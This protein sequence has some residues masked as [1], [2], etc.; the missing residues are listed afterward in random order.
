MTI[1]L[2]E[3]AVEL[4]K[5]IIDNDADVEKDILNKDFL[6]QFGKDTFGVG[7][8]FQPLKEGMDNYYA[9]IMESIFY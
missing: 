8:D 9:M 1:F 2:P 4:A 3:Y 6:D 7:V 5:Y